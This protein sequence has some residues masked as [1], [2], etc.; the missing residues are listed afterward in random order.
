MKALGRRGFTAALAGSLALPAL[1]WQARIPV[2]VATLPVPA[3][4][5]QAARLAEKQGGPLVLLVS[6]PGCPY[7]ELVRR[8][9][10]L[11]AR[12]ESSLEAW[13]LNINDNSTPLLDFDGKPTTAAVWT[14]AW[15][16]TFTPT[17]LFLGPE[18]QKLAEP[19]VGVAVPDFYGAYLDERLALARTAF[20]A[21]R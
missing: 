3:S 1:A 18:G 11:P 5:P 14:K 10:L 19:L 2:K 15:K 4:L 20:F 7:C 8:N 21:L 6:L 17:V 13:Q 16:A 12:N 9:Y